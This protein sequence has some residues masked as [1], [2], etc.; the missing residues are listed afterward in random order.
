MISRKNWKLTKAYLERRENIDLI[1]PGSL[2]VETTYLRY[3][4]EWADEASFHQAHKIRPSLPEYLITVSLDRERKPFSAVFIKK[5]LES[6]RKFFTWVMDTYSEYRTI[7]RDWIRTLKPRRGEELPAIIKIPSLDDI[8]KIASA[9]A[10][11]IV[12]R[13]I[14]AAAIFWFLS[15]IRIAAFVS[16]PIEAV[17]IGNRKIMQYPSLGVRTKNRKYATTTLYDIPELLAVL[18]D[19]DNEVHSALPSGGFW[20]APLSPD[21]REFDGSRKEVGKHREAIARKNLKA[22]LLKIGV[23]YY[24]PHKFRY[25]NIQYGLGKS[26]SRAD[27]K[28]VSMNVMHSNMDTTDEVYSRL[29]DSEVHARVEGLGKGGTD[30]AADT[31]AEFR[32]FQKFLEWQKQLPR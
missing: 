16:L 12:E 19:W 27:F 30:D 32:L 14:R 5:T 17:D 13:R 28:A 8:L 25:A 4:L 23:P 21:T 15:G 6:A 26:R 29:S 1:S 7:K 9:P 22:Y 31:E 3:I 18:R 10:D 11:N 24:A 20:F 2:K